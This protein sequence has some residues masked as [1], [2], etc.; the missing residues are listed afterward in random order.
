M[1]LDVKAGVFRAIY[2]SDM[3]SLKHLAIW[4]CDRPALENA[5]AALLCLDHLFEDL[6]QLDVSTEL[7]AVSSL[8]L[9]YVYADL[10]YQI[11]TDRRPSTLDTIQ[12]L[13]CC[14]STSDQVFLR[15][16]TY[17]GDLFLRIHLEPLSREQETI[18]VSTWQFT[19]LFQ[20]HLTARLQDRILDEIAKGSYV[21]IFNPCTAASFGSCLG[22]DCRLAH[23]MGAEWFNRRIRFTFQQILIVNIFQNLTIGDFPTRMKQRRYAYNHLAESSADVDSFWMIVRFWLSRLDDALNPLCSGHGS[24]SIVRID[25][26]AESEIALQTV[27]LWIPDVL[28]NLNPSR[29]ELQATFLT[30]FVKATT[31]G[32]FVDKR[33]MDETLDKI[34]CVHSWRQRHPRLRI[35]QDRSG[36]ALHSFVGFSKS[37]TSLDLTR[38]ASFFA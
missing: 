24:A 34:P 18:P 15:P 22:H 5:P 26:I 31:I 2:A 23:N 4:Y 30:N 7:R 3:T 19:Q 33:I 32:Y 29:L 10:M 38:G 8:R 20:R 6:G 14:Q 12:R 1:S 9:F 37:L 16:R 35:G 17:F 25:H 21:E 36:Y 27:K 28:Y 11:I 13:F